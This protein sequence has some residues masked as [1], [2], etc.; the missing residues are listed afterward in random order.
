MFYDHVFNQDEKQMLLGLAESNYLVKV[1]CPDYLK[2]S[3]HSIEIRHTINHRG[4]DRRSGNIVTTF[5]PRIH[6]STVQ[7][8]VRD[9][10]DTASKSSSMQLAKLFELGLGVPKQKD[11]A[12]YLQDYSRE[13][14]KKG[15]GIKYIRRLINEYHRKHRHSFAGSRWLMPAAYTANLLNMQS[16]IHLKENGYK[17]KVKVPEGV[18]VVLIYQCTNYAECEFTLCDAFMISPLGYPMPFA[19]IALRPEFKGAP[20]E[21]RSKALRGKGMYSMVMGVMHWEEGDAVANYRELMDIDADEYLTLLDS[22]KYADRRS[23]EYKAVLA[24]RDE[25]NADRQKWKDVLDKYGNTTRTLKPEHQALLDQASKYFADR[26]DSSDFFKHFSDI[27]RK[28]NRKAAKQFAVA[29]AKFAAIDCGTVIDR[30]TYM[31]VS[32]TL[33]KVHTVLSKWGFTT[34]DSVNASLKKSLLTYSTKNATRIWS[35]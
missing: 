27:E 16:F 8:L 13:N 10:R 15:V 32:T 14:D 35:L 29:S 18:P 34:V 11:I 23:P 17:N 33:D 2:K 26:S 9:V 25:M 20:K 22:E 24:K 7:R 3:K 1:D 12:L 21:F 19:Q 5:V 31:A 6:S 30:A 28:E 4:K